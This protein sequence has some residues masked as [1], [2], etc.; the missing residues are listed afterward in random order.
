MARWRQI[1]NGQAAM[2]ERNTGV[3]IEPGT[4]RIRPAPRDGRRH[5]REATLRTSLL[6]ME[7]VPLQKSR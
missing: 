6:S 5:V 7:R 2:A 4:M 1:N 3:R